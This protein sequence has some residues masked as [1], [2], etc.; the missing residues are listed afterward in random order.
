M[1]F[2]PSPYY[3]SFSPPFHDLLILPYPLLPILLHRHMTTSPPLPSQAKIP[4]YYL[5]F[6]QRQIRTPSYLK[7]NSKIKVKRFGRIK[8]ILNSLADDLR[9]IQR[10]IFDSVTRCFPLY[11][12]NNFLVTPSIY[13]GYGLPSA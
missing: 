12:Y 2:F 13:M 3:V 6:Q 1:L 10:S 7:T 4:A 5:T 11:K 8:I 9:K